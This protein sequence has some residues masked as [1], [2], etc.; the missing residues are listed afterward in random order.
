ML[1]SDRILL[2]PTDTE[3]GIA[4]ED[5]LHALFRAM[6]SLPGAELV[7]TPELGRHCAPPTDPMFKGVWA[8]QLAPER[9]DETIN[10]VLAWFA[11]RRAPFFFWWTGPSTRPT[12]LGQRL[13]ARGLI[14]MEA[15]AEHRTGAVTAAAKGAPGM[16]ADFDDMSDDALRDV[17]RGFAIETVR[18]EAALRD[19]KQVL[20]AAYGL[21][22]LTTQAWVD[23]TLA[24]GFERAPWRL[25][26]GRLDGE[27]VASSLL[28][29]GGGVVGV[30]AVGTVERARGKGIGGAITLAPLLE[31]RDEGYRHAVLFSSAI[32]VRAYERIGFRPIDAWIDRYL[33]RAA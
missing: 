11:K 28:F 24:F 29:T 23:A 26:L 25:Y 27:P 2:N 19:F 16:A 21:P 7:Q 17:P 9:V 33:W 30:Y 3:L 1:T 22:E 31:A 20:M 6:S 12:D 32:G 8:T 4:I 14:S 18:D 13:A 15:Q 5:N 10:E